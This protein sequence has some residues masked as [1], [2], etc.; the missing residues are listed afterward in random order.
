VQLTAGADTTSD[1]ADN[2]YEIISGSHTV[3][4]TAGQT[5]TGTI[6]QPLVKAYSCNYISAGILGLAGTTYNGQLDYGNGDCD[7]VATYTDSEGVTSTVQL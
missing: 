7:A 2:V 4:D 3:N 5:L 6:I 1:P